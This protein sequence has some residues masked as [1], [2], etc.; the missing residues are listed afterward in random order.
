MY[1]DRKASHQSESEGT[2][3]NPQACVEATVAEADSSIIDIYSDGVAWADK[4]FPGEEIKAGAGYFKIRS[5]D[6]QMHKIKEGFDITSTE[7]EETI[8]TFG[9]RIV[10]EAQKLGVDYDLNPD[11]L[12][13][14]I[15]PFA[16]ERLTEDIKSGTGTL[17]KRG[18]HVY[19]DNAGH[20]VLLTYKPGQTPYLSPI[21]AVILDDIYEQDAE[22]VK[23]E[24][25]SLFVA[26]INA[27]LKS[28]AEYELENHRLGA[29]LVPPF[30]EKLAEGGPLDRESV[31]NLFILSAQFDETGKQRV[32]RMGKTGEVYRVQIPEENRFVYLESSLKHRALCPAEP[33][34][35][36]QKAVNQYQV[37]WEMQNSAFTAP[38]NKF[39]ISE[40][41][42]LPD[43]LLFAHEPM[44]EAIAEVSETLKSSNDF[45]SFIDRTSQSARGVDSTLKDLKRRLP[46]RHAKLERFRSELGE[47]FIHSNN[48]DD[49][50]NDAARDLRFALSGSPIGDQVTDTEGASLVIARKLGMYSTNLSH[51]GE[52]W[53]RREQDGKYG[54]KT[55]IRD[56]FL[57]DIILYIVAKNIQ[58]RN[59]S[60]IESSG[61]AAQF[62]AG[63]LI[64]MLTEKYSHIKT[65]AGT[66]IKQLEDRTK[67]FDKLNK[68]LGITKQQIGRMIK[69]VSEGKSGD[70]SLYD[71]TKFG[72]LYRT[73]AYQRHGLVDIKSPAT[74]E[75]LNNFYLNMTPEDWAV[76]GI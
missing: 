52:D 7:Y 36:R 27:R 61:A 74:R 31:R 51:G 39:E 15:S 11:Q 14:Y 70:R 73:L 34:D 26:G 19:N 49:F 37:L 32:E 72:I 54:S 16:A 50:I 23:S 65:E 56:E 47:S 6:D 40:H 69:H 17:V 41:E 5:I 28:S 55:E 64:T 13:Q 9:E 1:T 53:V 25:R 2:I 29:D 20:A 59:D 45:I 12:A 3:F 75:M 68:N 4:F 38:Q 21:K 57:K 71:R 35:T 22:L 18:W 76:I 30:L 24:L 66:R 58:Q 8:A 33:N 44:A 10:G 67:R 60:V 48:F 62:A 43:P 46:G 42:I 63:K